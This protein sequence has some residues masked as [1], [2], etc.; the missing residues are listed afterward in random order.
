MRICLRT[1]TVLIVVAATLPSVASAN[2]LSFGETRSPADTVAAITPHPAIDPKDTDSHISSEK[3]RPG[4]E[5]CGCLG[6][7]PGVAR[8]RLAEPRFCP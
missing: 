3:V 7:P 6:L 4:R 5:P 8:A 2:D 1:V